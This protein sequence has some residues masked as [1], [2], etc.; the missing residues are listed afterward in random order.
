MRPKL[1]EFDA[2]D[3]LHWTPTELAAHRRHL[4]EMC[5]LTHAQVRAWMASRS[6]SVPDE[7]GEPLV[8]LVLFP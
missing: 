6:K 2:K 5:K 1:A 4:A 8:D 3:P 7:T